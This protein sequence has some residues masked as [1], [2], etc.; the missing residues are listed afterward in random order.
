MDRFN[1]CHTWFDG[2][3]SLVGLTLFMASMMLLCLGC[4]VLCLYGA[5]YF[6]KACFGPDRDVFCF[7]AVPVMLVLGLASTAPAFM[8]WDKMTCYFAAW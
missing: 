6:V 8:F 5:G 4:A 1:V 3:G 7:I 2:Q